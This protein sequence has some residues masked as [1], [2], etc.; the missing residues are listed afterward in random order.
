MT[1]LAV[2]VGLAL[3]PAPEARWALKAKEFVEKVL[4]VHT[5]HELLP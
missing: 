3:T 2:D 4:F 5:A 1:D